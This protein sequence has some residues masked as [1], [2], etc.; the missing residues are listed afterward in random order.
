MPDEPEVSPTPAAPAAAGGDVHGACP[1]CRSPIFVEGGVVKGGGPSEYFQ[2]LTRKAESAEEWR[3]KAAAL[4][5]EHTSRDIH[6]PPPDP[7]APVEEETES[8]F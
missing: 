1:V 7:N 6:E 8:F 2:E 3:N 5:H 4:E